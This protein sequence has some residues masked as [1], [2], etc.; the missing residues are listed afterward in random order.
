MSARI[1][2]I[3]TAMLAMKTTTASG[4]EPE[5][6][7]YTTPVR[8]VSFCAPNSE[9]VS[10]IGSMLAGMYRIIA[11]IRNAHVRARLSGLRK[12]R[13]APQRGQRAS[14]ACGAAFDSSPHS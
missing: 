13:C 12:C 14:W 1:L 7:R 3:G 2:S 6:Q 11:A 10:I 8:I 9:L 5:V 4:H